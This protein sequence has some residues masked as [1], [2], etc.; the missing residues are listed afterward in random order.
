MRFSHI[1]S[2][3]LRFR[4]GWGWRGIIGGYPNPKWTNT[5]KKEKR[6]IIAF[7]KSNVSYVRKV[8]FMLQHWPVAINY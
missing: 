6:T 7:V 5:G 1:F 2:E 8:Q 4:T 3:K